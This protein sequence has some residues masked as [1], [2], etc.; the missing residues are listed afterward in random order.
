MT[1]SLQGRAVRAMARA[2][3]RAEE[4]GK[5]AKLPAIKNPF[6]RKAR[7]PRRRPLGD[8]GLEVFADDLELPPFP[9]AIDGGFLGAA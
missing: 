4:S 6:W 1:P 7:G 8:G 9:P 3:L 2:F 5:R